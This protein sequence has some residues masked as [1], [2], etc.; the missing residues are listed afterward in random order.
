MS[1]DHRLGDLLARGLDD[2]TRVALV[3]FPSDEGVRRNGGRA[4]AAG[5]PTAIRQALVS[6]TSAAAAGP[7]FV[8]LLERTTDLGDVEVTG[9]VESD[10]ARLAA[11]LAPLLSRGIVPIILGGGHETTYGHFLGYVE[12]GHDIA[13]LNWDA[14]ADVRPLADGRG[15]SGSPFR[16]ALEHPSGHCRRYDV[17][18]LMPWRVAASHAAFVRERGGSTWWRDELTDERIYEIAGVA[19]ADSIASF[20]LDLVD[21][22]AAPGVSAPGVGGLAPASWLLAARAC[23]ENPAFASFDIV[24]MNPAFDSDGRT[25]TLAAL[26]VWHLLRGM[27]ARPPPG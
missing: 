27:A 6:M 12:C 1:D 11:T 14:H 4:G 19:G 26:T 7:G 8:A 2:N 9:D 13:I 18:G 17:A 16:Q 24:E 25:A 10:Q 21:A 20:D 23:G 22:S 15:H 5:G 3:G